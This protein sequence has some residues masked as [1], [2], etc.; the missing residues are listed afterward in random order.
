MS[1]IVRTNN[2]GFFDSFYRD[3][4]RHLL[5]WEPF[6]RTT[7]RSSF[8]PRFNV[9]EKEDGYY[10]SA[11]LPGLAEEDLEVTLHEGTLT[12]SGSRR[13]EQQNDSDTYYLYERS[14]GEFR[15]TF[16]L[17]DNAD[18]EAI[19]ASLK[20]GVLELVIGK[21]PEAKPRKIALQS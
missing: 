9:V 2:S 14:T 4:F 7:T 19:S 21:R 5:T 13:A 18:E 11:D 12:V 8:S 15:R 10:V 20:N 17:P 6:A 3:P 16:A 1:A